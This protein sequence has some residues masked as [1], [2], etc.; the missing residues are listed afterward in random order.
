MKISVVGGSG[1]VGKNLIENLVNK[2]YDVIS[3][4]IS[5]VTP[6]NSNVK[7]ITSDTTKPGK[8]QDEIENSDVVINLAGV[9]IFN[10]WSK[11][12]KE[13][14]YTSRILTTKNIVE[15]IDK[16]K[17]TTLLSTSAA[18][19]YGDRKDQL[20]NEDEKNGSDFLSNV[21][22]DWEREALKAKEKNTRVCL[23]RFGIVVGNGGALAKMIPLTKMML[24]PV[25]GNGSNF[26]PWI[27]VDD[28]CNAIIFLA[29][30]SDQNGAFN[31]TSPGFTTQKEFTYELAKNLNR[32][33]V[34]HIPKFFITTFAG[35]LGKSFLCSQ[36][37]NPKK[38]LDA[39]FKFEFENHIEA[40]KKTQ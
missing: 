22:K 37:A 17:K 34:F 14:I 1:F 23:M 7:Y 13:L 8:W 39:G 35:D 26:F 30:N 33:L 10:L 29:K 40:I 6:Q 4:D 15:A 12:Y 24:N 16:D 3:I 20:L 5:P 18:G 38:L 32:P 9:T 25:L 31:F 27:H 19:F 11:A 21:C 28:L 2:N 36:K